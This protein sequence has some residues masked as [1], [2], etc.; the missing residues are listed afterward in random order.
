MQYHNFRGNCCLHLQG[1]TQKKEAVGSSEILVMI[2]QI[3]WH[4]PKKII[5]FISTT[6]LRLIMGYDCKE[7]KRMDG[8]GL[9]SYPMGDS[10]IRDY[11]ERVP[12]L[13]VSCYT[14]FQFLL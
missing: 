3:M 4:L 11:E 14:F 5:I 12:V 1:T 9:E 13:L 6:A 7:E 8:N 2:Y 10:G